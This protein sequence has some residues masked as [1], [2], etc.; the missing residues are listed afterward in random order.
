MPGSDQSALNRAAA[1]T[2]NHKILVTCTSLFFLFSLV[3]FLRKIGDFEVYYAAAWRFLH[4]F[5]V[6]VPEPNMFTYPTSA[7][8][9]AAPLTIFGY[10]GAKV[11]YFLLGFLFLLI[12]IRLTNTLLLGTGDTDP[13][14]RRIVFIAAMICTS[15]YFLAVLDNQQTDLLIF[16]L[17]TLGVYLYQ[18]HR[19]GAALSW[20]IPVLLKANPMFMILLPLF[21]GRVRVV[22]A[23]L[24]IIVVGLALP[25]LVR[26][27]FE[28]GAQ[29][30]LT[31]PA[32]VMPRDGAIGEKV[33]LLTPAA[34]T[35]T[36]YLGE[37]LS[38]TLANV[39]PSWWEDVSN[40]KNQS[41]TRIL[42]YYS[43]IGMDARLLFLL[44]CAAFS[45]S[46]FW[47]LRGCTGGE[48]L[49]IT[50]LLC[51]S[52]FVLIGPVSSKPHFVMLYGLFVYAWHD[53]AR[54]FSW[55]RLLFITAAGIV[56]GFSSSGLL[57]GYADRL[58]TLGH[59]GLASFALWIYV[60][61][62]ALK[63]HSS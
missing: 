33:F 36:A 37:Y 53:L 28:P 45:A 59:I 15:R 58:A 38:I 50:G 60:Y 29:T 35:R 24:I 55:S 13:R 17:V 11:I 25:D 2:R 30:T 8:L 40:P 61:S 1:Y 62:A 12:G 47:L 19:H 20:A 3:R 52:A 34:G 23:M 10:A 54:R 49:A 18:Q 7:A 51:Y 27:A 5:S 31:V 39:G 6:H 14:T 22:M 63:R 9:L 46:L 57:S 16:G 43:P 44:L 56:L 42:L 4:G 21:Q 32:H 26:P 48:H 41:L